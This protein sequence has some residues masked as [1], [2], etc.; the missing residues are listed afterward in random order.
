MVILKPDNRSLP[1]AIGII[2]CYD[3]MEGLL[4]IRDEKS[5]RIAQTMLDTIGETLGVKKD[6]SCI[7]IKS[8]GSTRIRE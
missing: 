5:F 7:K 3:Y 1:P 4:E 6:E 8:W 2:C